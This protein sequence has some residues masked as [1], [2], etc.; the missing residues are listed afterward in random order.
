MS[1]PLALSPVHDALAKAGQANAEQCALAHLADLS[2]LPRAGVKGAGAA[3]WLAALG[4]PLPPTANSWLALAQGGL[5]ARLGQTEYLVD[6]D[7]AAAIAGAPRSAG[8]YPVLRQ[9]A[10]FA[11]GGARIDEL[12]LQTC[13]VD[14]RILDA[15]PSKL[16]MT[17][18]VGVS[19]TVVRT[20]GECSPSYRLWCDGTYGL[21]LW[22]TL[23][24][25]IAELG[26]GV[27]PAPLS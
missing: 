23:A 2:L 1:S 16:V 24:E 22:D 13:N 10:S 5:I 6:G 25:I 15:D 27:A 21:Y 12:L 11:I 18:I 8:V 9:D 3:D 4:L 14:F 19:V 17:S 20:P 7:A 26:G